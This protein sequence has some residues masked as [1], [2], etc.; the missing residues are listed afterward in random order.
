MNYNQK[1]NKEH[2][3]SF[4]VDLKKDEYAELQEALKKYGIT[5]AQF[6]RKAI[7]RFYN[8]KQKA[9]NSKKA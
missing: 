7:E 8:D 3:S 5:K 9:N 6:L 2:Y 1:Y 4:K